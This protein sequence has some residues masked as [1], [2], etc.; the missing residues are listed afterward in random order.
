MCYDWPC[1][2]FTGLLAATPKAI[3]NNYTVQT[4]NGECHSL[5]YRHVTAARS[6]ACAQFT[7]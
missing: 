1:H 4:L 5:H 2:Y 6:C 7:S 3:C